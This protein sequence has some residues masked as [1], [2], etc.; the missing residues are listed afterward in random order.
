MASIVVTFLPPTA[1]TGVTQERIGWP[2]RWTVQAP[3]SAM[4]QPNFVPVK[5]TTSRRAHRIGMS[6]GTS[7]V[8][9]L[10]LMLS[11]IMVVHP[12]LGVPFVIHVFRVHVDNGAADPTGLRVPGYV[13]THLELPRH[14]SSH[15]TLVPA[16]S[17]TRICPAA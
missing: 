16:T 5:P 10:P 12:S 2:A 1:A 7:T 8:W 13:I 9:S 15:L 6:V 14:L 3:Q 11:V 4:P 17:N